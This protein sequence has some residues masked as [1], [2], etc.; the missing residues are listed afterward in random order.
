MELLLVLARLVLAGVF[1]VSGVGKLLDLKGS[2]TAMRGFGLPDRLAKPAGIALPFVEVLVALLLLPVATATF[3]AWAALAL[4]VAFIAGISYNLAKGQ[5]PDCHCFGQFH[6][7]PIGKPTLIRN[8]VLAAVALFI[9]VSGLAGNPGPSLVEWTRGSGML[10]SVLLVLVIVEALALAG[11]VWLLVH[12]LGQSGRL[13][14]RMDRIEEALADADIEVAALDDDEEAADEG[15]GLPIGAPAP[16]FSLTGLYGE[17]MTLDSLRSR[18]SPVVLVF[19][20][21]TCGPCNALMP[22]IGRWQRDLG[23]KLTVALVSGGTADANKG[24]ASEHGIGN[25]LLQADNEVADAYRT[26]G[27]PTGVLVS[28]DGL[29]ASGAAPGGAAIRKLVDQ[30]AEGKVPAPKRLAPNAVPVQPKPVR[31]QAPVPAAN[32]GK[33]A[34]EVALSDLDGKEVRLADFRGQPTAVLFWNPGCGFCQRMVNDLKAW[35]ANPPAN[36]PKLLIVSTGDVERNR[37]QGFASPV[38]LDSGFNTGRALGASGTPSAVLV[39]ADGNIASGV[40]VGAPGVFGVL[41]NEA[42][43][44]APAESGNGHREPDAPALGSPAP[45]VRMPDINGNMVDLA[46]HRGTRT[47]LLFWN[48]GCGFCEKMV[49][50]LKAWEANPPAGAPKL[51][52][53]S[54]GSADENRGMGLR[55]P[56]LLDQDFSVGNAFGAGGTPTA[57]MVDA[58]GNIASTLAVGKSDVMELARSTGGAQPAR[59]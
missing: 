40:A 24:K 42:P 23:G 37:D 6:S 41:R 46:D 11:V 8:G 4:L 18:G 19:T 43:A 22:D 54:T 7:E 16:A 38:V 9:G 10:E 34:P 30:A 27:T 25:V 47:L 31:V 5:R 58:Q 32:L 55:S 49:D 57:L 15:E 17:T 52:L 2:E 45:I 50:D 29:I 14:I 36:A 33:P 1:A 51:M 48:P 21:P 26:F 12:L 20:D 35:E 53:I 13:L 3:G 28:A 56:I 39:D 44:P 59:V